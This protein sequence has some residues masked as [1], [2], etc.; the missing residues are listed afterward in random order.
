M[1]KRYAELRPEELE[2]AMARNPL[3]VLPWGALEWHGPHLPLGLDGLVA[4]RFCERLAEAADAVL[5]PTTWWPMTTLP[6][7]FS[8][9]ISTA[10]ARALW[11]EMIDELARA[12]FTTICIVT[13]HYAQG[14]EM[15]L[16]AV[17]NEAMDRH[18]QLRVICASPLEPMMAPAQLDHA[19]LHETAQLLAIR[20]ELVHLEDFVEGT[21]AATRA[22][23]RRNSE[24]SSCGMRLKPGKTY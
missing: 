17:A 22:A 6:H 14:H 4:E 1:I 16:Y 18:T 9:Q 10:T 2:S 3:A 21:P 20:P 19:G 8:L 11:R 15:E 23:P 13:G 24:K 12:G 5:L 7:R